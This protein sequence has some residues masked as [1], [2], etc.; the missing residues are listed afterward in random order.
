MRSLVWF[1]GKDLRVAD[2]G[3]LV[4]AVA[5]GEVIPLFVLDPHFFAPERA[6]AMAPR[7]Q[8]LLEALEDLENRI[9]QLGSKLI[10][11]SGRSVDVLPQWA[12]RWQ[13]DRGRVED[14]EQHRPRFGDDLCHGLDEPEH[15]AVVAGC[16]RRRR[17]DARRGDAPVTG[18][19]VVHRIRKPRR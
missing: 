12:E 18:R 17:T 5:A 7:M 13:A 16:D 2:H 15:E 14:D 9:A 4:E 1:R 19:C 11:V 3:P 6:R 8:V 10:F